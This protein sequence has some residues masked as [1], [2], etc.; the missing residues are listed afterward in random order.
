[1][2]L[3][4]NLIVGSFS[5]AICIACYAQQDGKADDNQAMLTQLKQDRAKTAKACFEAT[6]AAYDAGTIT[7]DLVLTTAE[8]LRDAELAV[9]KDDKQRLK[10]LRAHLERIK[11]IRDK[12]QALQRMGARGGEAEKA[13][14]SE[15]AYQDA[16]IAVLSAMSAPAEPK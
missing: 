3:V 8:K 13:L 5:I 1:M 11:P 10:S 4:R 12:I 6:Q 2:R 14:F 16:E 9:A 7:L 15:L